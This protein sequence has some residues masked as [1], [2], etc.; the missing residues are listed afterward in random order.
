VEYYVILA[1][2]PEAPYRRFE[3]ITVGVSLEILP[4]IAGEEEIVMSIIP[5]VSDVIKREEIEFP[6][7]SR[8]RVQ[9]TVRVKD[10]QTVI[11][12]GLLQNIRRQLIYEV[13]FLSKIPIIDLFFRRETTSEQE[14]ELVIFITP[15]IVD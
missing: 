3:T 4:R 12:G 9:T 15:R 13:P 8:R 6:V 5:Q 11:I 2:P 14:T 10:G 7:V 1:G